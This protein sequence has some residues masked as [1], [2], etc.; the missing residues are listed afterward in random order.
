MTMIRKMG[1]AAWVLIGA[2]LGIVA[3]LVLGER[4]EALVPIS[5][6]YTMMLEIAIY[7]Y[8]VCALILGLGRLAPDRVG[9]LL[10][11]S[12]PPFVFVWVLALA[13][14]TLLRQAIPPTPPPFVIHPEAATSIS[15]LIAVLIPAN[16]FVA[17]TTN[18]V[19]AIVVL[20]LLYGIGVQGVAQRTALFDVLEAIRMASL[21]IWKWIV[22]LTPIGV[23]ALLAHTAGTLRPDQF[24]GFILYNIL[25]LTGTLVLA[26]VALPLAAAAIAPMTYGALMAE[27]RPGFVLSLVTGLPVLS[28]PYIERTAAAVARAAGCPEGQETDDVI[29]ATVSL[30]YGLSQ[31]GNHFCVLLLYYAAYRD[32]HA[33]PLLKQALLPFLTVLSCVG[34]PSTVIGAVAF[35]SSWLDL[36]AS[37]TGLWIATSAVTRY[38]QVMAS[39]GA[40]GLIA[41]AVPLF[42]WGKWRLRLP[43]ACAALGLPFG[44]LASVVVLATVL[45]P[46]L[47]PANQSDVAMTRTIDPKLRAGLAVQVLRPGTASS[48]VPVAV[49]PHVIAIQRGGVL[50]V[51]YNPNVIPFSYVNKDG[52][53][54]GYDISF[55]YRLARD[56]AVRLEFVPY[57]WDGLA[58]DLVA[59]RFDLAVSGI[60]LTDARLASLTP[61]PTYW[62]T[63][64]ALLAPSVTAPAFT[65]RAALLAKRDLRLAVF[66]STVMHQLASTLFPNAA[67]TEVPDYGVLPALAGKVDAALWTLTQAAAWAHANPGWTAVETSDAGGPQ[68]IAIMLPPDATAFRAYVDAW[69]RLQDDSGFAAE[70]KSYWIDGIPRRPPE[71]RWNLLDALTGTQG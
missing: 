66:D 38:G 3:G 47:F 15:G 13:A 49:P 71:P 46:V 59:G 30:A 39:V 63:P 20:A 34:T 28:L 6:A 10:R 55:A 52:D 37:T 70:Q 48:I 19:P 17:L 4:T 22:R 50:R 2:A 36:P 42:Y 33:L 14:I 24:G 29:K 56:L 21:T 61:G 41:S 12:W 57:T 23:F 31:V 45:R 32:G 51:G 43:T 60:Y 16:P 58:G 67:I 8:L 69:I 62:V 53:L 64:V 40:F 25:F 1:L 7:P 26:F 35:F 9:R 54:V 5:S 68:P 44:V 65:S 18:D 11:A 27:L